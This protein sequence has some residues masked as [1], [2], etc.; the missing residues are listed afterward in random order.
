M[1]SSVS[2]LD[3]NPVSLAMDF[4]ARAMRFGAA[5]VKECMLRSSEIDASSST[6]KLEMLHGWFILRERRHTG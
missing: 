2:E 4:F 6:E 1:S 5:R 3:P